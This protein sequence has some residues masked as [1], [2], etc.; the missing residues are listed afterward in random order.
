MLRDEGISLRAPDSVTRED[1]ALALDTTES[2]T[3]S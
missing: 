3:Y 1:F 2:R